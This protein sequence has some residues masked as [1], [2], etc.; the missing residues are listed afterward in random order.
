M[1]LFKHRHLMIETNDLPYVL[2]MLWFLQIMDRNLSSQK[3][4]LYFF[5]IENS[6]FIYF[7]VPRKDTF[8]TRFKYC[9][10]SHFTYIKWWAQRLWIHCEAS[11]RLPWSS[12]FSFFLFHFWNLQNFQL[13]QCVS[14][15][16]SLLF[17]L[18]EWG[19]WMQTSRTSGG[20]SKSSHS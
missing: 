10:L 12:E 15:S 13:K 19:I 4:N 5:L 17:F 1:V 14:C 6:L 11:Q 9:Y 18:L 16:M 20:S 7:Q 3:K 8:A 2:D